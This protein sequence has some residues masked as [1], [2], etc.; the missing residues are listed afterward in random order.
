MQ[1]KRLEGILLAAG[2]SRRMGFPKPLLRLNG[3]TFLAHLAAS[4]LSA[5]ERLVIVL[6]A[7]RE[8]VAPAVPADD[9]II[10][11]DNPDYKLGQLS[12][13]KRG[14]RTL[15]A[16]ADAAIV[17]LIDHPTVLAQTFRRLADEYA[18]SGK[19]ILITRCGRRRGH[20]VLF[21]RSVFAEL[22]RAPLEVG[23]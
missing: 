20:P 16:Q 22:E 19:P 7:H 2:E 4:M 18:L 14:L 13:I 11:I 5:V 3:E 12:S 10:T 23:A 15:S 9:R 1:R 8:A 17:H 21:D 6:G